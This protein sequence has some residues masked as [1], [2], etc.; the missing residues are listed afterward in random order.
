[1]TGKS[2]YL[3]ETYRGNVL[4]TH[5]PGTQPIEGLLTMITAIVQQETTLSTDLSGW[6]AFKAAANAATLANAFQEY[7]EQKSS[8]TLK[9]H[10]NDLG[11]FLAFLQ[12]FGFDAMPTVE[13]LNTIPDSWQGMSYGIIAQ[14]RD[15]LKKAGYA[16]RTINRYLSTVKIY[17][18]LA[19]R[20]GII[21]TEESAM[22]RTVTGYTN[23]DAIDE[24]RLEMGIPTRISTK[25][26][27]AT[28]ITPDF[29]RFLKNCHDTDSQGRR[30][31]LLMTLLLDTGI[32][33]GDVSKLTGDN[34]EL[35][36]DAQSSYIQWIPEKTKRK[37]TIVRQQMT[38]DLFN[39]F[40][41]YRLQMPEKELQILRSSKRNGKLTTPGMSTS[42]IYARVR[43]IGSKCGIEKLSPHDCRHSGAKRIQ[44][45]SKDIMVTQSWGGWITLDMPAHY[46]RITGASNE[47]IGQI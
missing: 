4:M 30:D 44:R 47:G 33:C 7:R 35:G 40:K 27:K 28:E 18:K 36:N 37:G 11:K 14:Y 34:I 8:R 5:R 21:P 31:R 32:R 22:I 24:K 20:A 45:A 9:A 17:C 42:A 19:H 16:I 3:T 29:V 13:D 25:K 46:A 10:D 39:A 41:A 2:R 15:S 38:P 6:D 1:M 43:S 26:T 23:G 12:S